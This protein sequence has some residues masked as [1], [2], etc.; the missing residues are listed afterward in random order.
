MESRINEA[1]ARKRVNAPLI[2]G[3]IVVLFAAA[4]FVFA[5]TAGTSVSPTSVAGDISPVAHVQDEM[6]V[7]DQHSQVVAAGS[8]VA[9]S[10]AGKGETIADD[11]T[12]LSAYPGKSAS[13]AF[14]G[15]TLV[16][17]AGILMACAFF[18][19]STRRLN[20]DIAHMKSSIP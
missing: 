3:A 14:D 15:I 10:V 16:L 11:E 19:I 18:L 4:V 1:P 6:V 9:N 7:S 13:G 20:K 17:L 2:V 5:I 8:A 12:P